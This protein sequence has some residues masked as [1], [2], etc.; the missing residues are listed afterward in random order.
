MAQHSPAPPRL[1]PDCNGFPVVAID[2]G[3]LLDNGTRATLLVACHLCR[4][5]GSPRT[6]T[7]APVVQREH[8]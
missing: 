2:T 7:P 3:T 4:G 8:A 6:A 5:T 1:C